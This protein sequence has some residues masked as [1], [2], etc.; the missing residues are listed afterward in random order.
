MSGAG[1]AGGFGGYTRFDDIF[2]DIFRGQ[3]RRAGAFFGTLIAVLIFGAW[4]PIDGMLPGGAGQF[5][6]LGGVLVLVAALVWLA[7]LWFGKEEA[8]EW[9]RQTYLLLR[10][11]LPIFIP[12]VIVIGLLVLMVAFLF[13]L[14]GLYLIVVS[15]LLGP[16]IEIGSQSLGSGATFARDHALPF[17]VLV[18]DTGM[19]DRFVEHRRHR[20]RQMEALLADVLPRFTNETLVPSKPTPKSSK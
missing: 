17:H 12:A 3:A 11:I 6:R 18:D 20:I 13:P 1:H 4:T 9:G 5:L 15:M 19:L 8:R 14:S 2:G 10:M 16:E 7:V